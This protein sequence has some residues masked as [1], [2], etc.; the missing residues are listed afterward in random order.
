M[1]CPALEVCPGCPHPQDGLR[2]CEGKWPT[3][4]PW[5]VSSCAGTGAVQ[6]HTVPRQGALCDKIVALACVG[7]SAWSYT[8]AAFSL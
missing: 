4:G 5:Q 7:G 3:W 2:L 8:L 1:S 6:T